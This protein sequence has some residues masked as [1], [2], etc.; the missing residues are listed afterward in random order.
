MPD[1]PPYRAF[2]CSIELARVILSDCYC[3]VVEGSRSFINPTKFREARVLE[4]GSGIGLLGCLFAPLVKHYIVTDLPEMLP[5]IQKNMDENVTKTDSNPPQTRAH[6]SKNRQ[7]LDAQVPS[8]PNYSIAALD[9]TDVATSAPSST[10]RKLVRTSVLGS[11]SEHI[12][13]IIAVD[14]LYN[15]SLVSPFLATL[16][17]FANGPSTKAEGGVRESTAV[18]VVCEL[19]D[20]DVIR[21]FLEG[22]LSLGGWKVWRVGDHASPDARDTNNVTLGYGIPSEAFFDGPFVAWLGWKA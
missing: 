6:R 19:R 1:A 12:D 14:T 20:E 9:W 16:E 15:T 5:L 4:L 21:V 13:L 17:E 8:A 11:P 10:A 3:P 22:W 7:S 18:L 2:S